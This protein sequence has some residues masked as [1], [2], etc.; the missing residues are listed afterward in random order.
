MIL[1]HPLSYKTHVSR[2]FL[3]SSSQDTRHLNSLLHMLSGVDLAHLVARVPC[4][5]PCSR[6]DP[7]PSYC[8]QLRST[9]ALPHNFCLSGMAS[10][11]EHLIPDPSTACFWRR[12]LEKYN[13]ASLHCVV[14]LAGGGLFS[15]TRIP[16]MDKTV[17]IASLPARPREFVALLK[18]D[19]Y[20]SPALP[21]LGK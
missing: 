8:I 17:L 15:G 9:V 12:T 16:I 10:L 3:H 5:H 18:G 20:W 14:M 11:A 2:T 13:G 1:H 7:L 19:D 21:V 6:W 4:V